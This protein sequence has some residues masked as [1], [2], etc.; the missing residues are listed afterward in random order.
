M[1]GIHG[2][3]PEDYRSIEI[4]MDYEKERVVTL[5]DS[6]ARMVAVRISK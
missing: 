5:G 3:M 4:M 1:P 6:D 2:V